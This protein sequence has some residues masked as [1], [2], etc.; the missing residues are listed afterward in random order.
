MKHRLI[1]TAL[2]T[3]VLVARLEDVADAVQDNLDQASLLVLEHVDEGLD[4]A[5]LN[6]VLSLMQ[7]SV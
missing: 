1:N 5:L 7:A 4:A 3:F 6:A 2:L